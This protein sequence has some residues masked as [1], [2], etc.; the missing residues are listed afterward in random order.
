M[1]PPAISAHLEA[2]VCVSEGL[3]CPL[4]NFVPFP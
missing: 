2:A 1:K 3:D 4:K